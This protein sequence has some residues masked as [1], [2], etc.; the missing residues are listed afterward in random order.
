MTTIAK[1]YM[2]SKIE[3]MAGAGFAITYNV[4]LI[5]W[6]NIKGMAM[7]EVGIVVDTALVAFIGAYVGHIAKKILN[8]KK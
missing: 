8:R 1:D 3:E 4:L 6:Q 2:Y 7:H 5:D